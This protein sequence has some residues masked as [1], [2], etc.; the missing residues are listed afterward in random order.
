M[1]LL[2]FFAFLGGMVTILS[3]C[4]LPILPIVLSGSITGG[5]QRPWGVVVGFIA[6][7]TFFTL[8]LS[9]LIKATNVSADVLRSVSIVI[10]AGFGVS[11]LVPVF[12]KV[13]E[14]LFSRLT[15]F[16]PS[17][18]PSATRSDFL[19][20][21]L[22]GLSLGLLWTPCVGPILASIITLAATS[23]VTAD[24]IIITLAY[25]VGTAVPLLAITYGGRSLLSKNP[26]LVANT[27]RIQKGF[28]V[29]MILTAIAIYFQAD[30]KFQT[31]ILERFPAYGAGL[32]KFEDST[33]IKNAL[34]QV[35]NPSQRKES[36]M[37]DTFFASDL[38]NAPELIPGGRWF[39]LPAGNTSLSIK[40]L[41]GQVVLIDFWTYT[42][43]NCIRTLPYLKLW[44]EKYKDKGLTIIGVHTPEF[45]FEKNPENVL[46]A[47]RDFGLTYPVMQDNDYATWN[48]YA[49][50]YWPAKYLIDKNG[51][52]RYT[53]FGEGDYDET[54]TK[55]QELLKEAGS[56]SQDLPMDNPTYRVQSRTPETYFGSLRGDYSRITTT[57]TWTVGEEYAMPAAGA[58]LSFRFDAAEVFLVTRP[59]TKGITGSIR[60]LL[61]GKLVTEKNAG[62][63]VVSGVV[64]VDADR[65]YK[66]IKLPA[67]G[68]HLLEL[69][70]LDGNLE[71]YAF[72]FG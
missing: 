32:T 36:S 34:Q 63:D 46:R 26:W 29:L 48:A 44:H 11:L 66:L 65:L 37:L 60:V 43:I 57:G 40:G 33:A 30:R 52:I 18:T 9:A 72:T 47:I 28:G 12:Q 2:V 22:V 35:Q 21:L 10:V 69:E 41:R 13:I 49:N 5:K 70:F 20:G 4:I 54:E 14:R 24:A 53:H 55:I 3:P 8:F 17:Q 27:I 42:C 51:V 68:E 25:A 7:F 62:A 23:R 1:V 31:Y 67:A 56:L 59:K 45:E 61:D 39:N 58:K 38:G 6:S 64:K 50:R 19:S 16:V 71:L 15:S